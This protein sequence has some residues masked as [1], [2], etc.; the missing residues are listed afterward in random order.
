[1]VNELTAILIFLLYF[2]F[3]F[4][5][6]HWAERKAA[7]GQS[8]TNNPVV[9]SLSIAVY[10]TTWTYYGSVG[11]A[12][13][14]GML[15]ITYFI[16]PTIAT[17]CWWIVLRKLVRIKNTHRITSIAD[18]ISSRYDKSGAL[19]ALATIV[20]IVGIMPYIAL[21]LKSILSTVS[22]ITAT[23]TSSSL[24]GSHLS[25]IVVG[26]L[27]V[28]TII[29]GVRRLDPTERHEGMVMAL[30]VECV[31]KL[32]A[33]V[34]VGLFVTYSVFDGFTDIFQQLSESAYSSLMSVGGAEK[35][36]YLIWTTYIILSMS[37]IIF[38]PRQ[39]HIAVVENSHETHILTAMWLFP[40]YLLVINIFVFPIAASGLL[41]GF[42]IQDADTFVLQIPLYENK[43]WLAMLVFIGGFSAAVGMIMISSMTLSTMVTNHLLLPLISWIKWLEF[44]KRH[45][46]KC[47]W[48]SVGLVI[49]ASYLFER[50]VGGTYMLVNIGMIS[51]SAVLQFAPSILGGIFWHK[52][53][54]A[55][56]ITGLSAGFIVWVYTSMTPTLIKSGWM[57]TAILENGPW[58]ISFLNPEQLFGLSG[59][60]PLSN[61][62]FWSMLVNIGGYVLVS[63]IIPQSRTEQRLAEEFVGA[64][65]AGAYVDRSTFKRAYIDLLKKKEEIHR[66]LMQYFSEKEAFIVTEKCCQPLK[67]KKKISITELLKLHREVERFLSG[68][69]GAA[70]AHKAISKNAV[71][72]SQETK[73]L[74]AVYGEILADFRVS[75][76]ELRA[77]IDY[78][79]EKESL[80]E[81]HAGELEKLNKVLELR[82]K[83]QRETEKALA[84]SERK[85]RSIF[86]NALEGIFQLSPEKYFINV[87]PSMAQILGY[88]SP[89][90][91]IVN[92][93]NVEQQL[94]V[95]PLQLRNLLNELNQHDVV[96]NFECQF[97]RKDR[98]L[99]WV[100][101]QARA[102]R[103]TAENLIGIEGFIQ[104]ISNRKKAEDA[105]RQAYLEMENRVEQR[106]AEL[107][108][109]NKELQK[110][111]EKA[112]DATRAKSEFLA[113]MSHEIRTPMNGIIAA[114][115]LALD[116][117]MPE[118]IQHY[119]KI[120]HTSAYSLLGLINDIL[121][122]SKIEAG[123]LDLESHPFRLDELLDRVVEMFINKTVEK[124]IEVLVDIATDT[125]RALIGDYHRIQQIL[126]NLLSNAV[127]FTDPGGVILIGV[128]VVQ[129]TGDCISL[130]IFVKDTGIGIAPEYQAS[131]FECFSQADSSSTRKYQGTGLGLCICD[132][133]IKI[134]NGR[135]YFSSTPREGSTFF[136]TIPLE[137]QPEAELKKLIPPSDIQDLKVMVV[138]DCEDSRFIMQK[139]LE[140]FN[141]KVELFSSGKEA[142][143]RLER[144]D[145]AHYPIDL[146]LIDWLMPEMNGIEASKIIR[147]KL[148]LTQPIIL[149]TA[150]GTDEEKREA[151]KAEIN[152]FLTK[153]IYP[154]TLF[155]AIMD[156]F[157]KEPAGVEKLENYIT[158]KASIY[159]NRLRGL[160]V[161]V[162]EDNFTNQQ[163]AQAILEKAGI[164]VRIA[165]NGKEAIAAIEK[166]SYDAV[167][168]DIQMPEMD[169]Y[170]ATSLIRK[171]P[172]FKSLP[173]IAMTAHAMKGDEEKCLE[174]GMDGYIS[175]PVN[176]DRL[177]YT[178]WKLIQPARKD[179]LDERPETRSEAGSKQKETAPVPDEALPSSLPGID[180]HN[181]MKALDIAPHT[182]KKILSGFVKNNRETAKR[183]L[184][185]N[186]NENWHLLHRI[187][188]SLKGSAANLGANRLY[189]AAQQVEPSVREN[190]HP[191]PELIREVT[192]ALD[193]V[194]ASLTSLFAGSDADTEVFNDRPADPLALQTALTRLSE[195]LITA[196]PREVNKHFLTVKH[197][198]KSPMVQKLEQLINHYDYDEA[199]I[200]LKQIS[201][202]CG[203]D[204]EKQDGTDE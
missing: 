73:D 199:L 148:K 85:Y 106:T 176:Q 32:L 145:I 107:K 101:I 83:K 163:I 100:L 129:Q 34:T 47:K 76:E 111:K 150:F 160:N 196:A 5:I 189:Q 9:Y 7:A 187:C 115:D 23:P 134:M 175:K 6:A 36:P 44:L 1:M 193:Q 136:F 40:L 142:L 26:L 153:P 15:F 118:K 8:I 22:I 98:S 140:S 172:R 151:E 191:E 188:H 108:K 82:I 155:D 81:Q 105:L 54:K 146:I 178:M 197:N 184:E 125:P 70:A 124:K 162:A 93:N 12:A 38:L 121:D 149:M 164:G 64:L 119:M 127:K 195:A 120:I 99:I 27:I 113:N 123:K 20:A 144:P 92:I 21:Q 203:L 157:G 16:G 43:P 183:I 198:L 2:G 72:T 77:K 200:T 14:T 135:I 28:F 190:I 158:T 50:T 128:N 192:D 116:E 90:D 130:S 114:T 42:S 167:L 78:Y 91:L 112:E 141:F 166:E 45:L 138:D 63:L 39:F 3:L 62:L 17:V 179:M 170:E 59:L 41:Q 69:I 74:M 102:I 71:F 58:G 159:K 13:T 24:V 19:A 171:N 165:N 51:F 139:I 131:L 86:E 79:Q 87:S 30:A 180:I 57:S 89:E 177:F 147:E 80:L 67:N 97:Y 29:F 182:F 137:L 37:A 68:S 181:A 185:A 55:G 84:E 194:I 94:C 110:T 56:A 46:L 11:I 104:D 117:E 143:L 33:L 122:F 35:S 18:F 75:P 103:N 126:I 173:I 152:A 109:M 161:L 154:S 202:F 133:L 66:L 204:Q 201:E 186:Q 53:N 4:L 95:T 48:A 96:K 52:G 31:I 65:P 174:A 10:C 61:T 169:G 49:L 132:K 88:D 25:S 60:I 168:M 156:A